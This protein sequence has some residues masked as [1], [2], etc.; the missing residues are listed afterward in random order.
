M[1]DAFYVRVRGKISGPFDI[2]S[3]QK[4]VRRGALSRIHE[5]SSDRAAWNAAGQYEDLFPSAAAP[6]HQPVA[7]E[8]SPA[9]P[10]SDV[11]Q[12]SAATA[13]SHILYFYTQ[14]GSTVGPVP[15]SVLKTLAENGTLHRDDLV[16][17]ENAD[18]GAPAAQ[19]P[20]LAPIFGANGSGRPLGYMSKANNNLHPESL[21][22]AVAAVAKQANYVGIT[23]GA[24]ILLLMN[25]P[26]FTLDKKIVCWWDLYQA[27]EGNVWACF[28][29]MLVLS[30]IALCIIA[31][32]LTGIARGVTYLSLMAGVWILLCVAMTTTGAS[33][34]NVAAL[35][36]PVALSLLAGVCAFRAKSPEAVSGRVLLG[37]S[38]G[39]ISLGMLIA[40]L[41]AMQER[42][43]FVD[44]PGGVITGG[45]L[46]FLGLLSGLAAGVM[47]F[48]GL[49]AIFT[50]GLNQATRITSL[51]GL[52]LPGLGIFVAV[53]AVSQEFFPVRSGNASELNW[54]FVMVIGRMLMIVYACTAL[55]SVGIHELLLA[56]RARAIDLQ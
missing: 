3:L 51:A 6:S 17:R 5:I 24:A 38:S 39:I 8:N 42:R 53:S 52:L 9:K 25:V 36:V 26:W 15:L 35:V 43:P 30:G 47:G 40:I 19:M 12:I 54:I 31:P 22:A 50:P 55:T 2:A 48:V 32:L 16:W 34:Q 56:A 18:T 1:A 45:I 27:P 41:D 13:S 20:A 4:L 23:V 11:P 10:E 46:V 44:V 29:T 37:I 33:L 14:R 21:K 28:A 7:V 49:K